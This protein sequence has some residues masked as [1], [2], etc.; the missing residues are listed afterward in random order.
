MYNEEDFI[1]VNVRT[2]NKWHLCKT[3]MNKEVKGKE[4]YNNL[5]RIF[6]SYAAFLR[7]CSLSCR[8]SK[9]TSLN[10]NHQMAY[11]SP[12]D[13][14]LYEYEYAEPRWNDTSRETEELG[15]KPVPV[16]LCPPQISYGLTRGLT[17]ASS[18]RRRCLTV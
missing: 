12:T 18:V 16:P 1:C 10:C 8:W 14:R 5:E 7:Y 2:I 3:S 17:L 4:K 15:E 11:C 13:D 9:T 6:P